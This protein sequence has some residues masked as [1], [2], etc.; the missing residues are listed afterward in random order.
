MTERTAR[1]PVAGWLPWLA[2]L[3]VVLGA[4][5][6]GTLGGD[7]PSDEE[8]AQQLAEGIRCPQCASQSV[9]QSETPSA[10]GVKVVIADRIAA[11]NSD[12]EIRDFVA[13]RYG[14]GVLLDPSG[15]GFGALVW[16]LPVAGA[17][18]AVAALAFRFR[19]WRPSAGTVT[20]AD[21]DLVADA[22]AGAGD[23][24]RT[25]GS[26]PVGAGRERP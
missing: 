12:E 3:V 24:E 6:V 2:V 25:D 22:L 18:V 16:G 21:R 8:R 1:S 13:S 17:V 7:A 23:G 19:D 26:A 9:A 10:K 14:R 4:L 11:G 20:Q 5:A 15:E